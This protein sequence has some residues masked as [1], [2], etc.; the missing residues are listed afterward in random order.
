MNIPDSI[1]SYLRT[2]GTELGARVLAQFPALHQPSD[3][4]WPAL[5]L[6]RRRPFPAQQLAIMGIVKR[7]QE[8]RCAAAAVTLTISW[9]YRPRLW[10]NSSLCLEA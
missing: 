10:F 5:K 3:P 7:W 1:T 8:A 9:P 2:Y 6:L 4:A